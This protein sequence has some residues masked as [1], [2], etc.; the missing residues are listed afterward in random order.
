MYLWN[1]INPNEKTSQ[2]QNARI[3]RY[4]Q[5]GYR[6]TQLEALNKFGCLRLSARILDLKNRGHQIDDEFVHDARTGKV[7]KAY[8]LEA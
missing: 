2:S 7:Y 3:L 8:F 1:N 5:A 4:L 6:L